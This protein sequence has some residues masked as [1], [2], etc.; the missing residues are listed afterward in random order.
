M[1][2]TFA[3]W[4]CRRSPAAKSL[5]QPSSRRKLLSSNDEKVKFGESVPGGIW[6]CIPPAA[7]DQR[8]AMMVIG[9]VKACISDFSLVCL[10]HGTSNRNQIDLSLVYLDCIRIQSNAR[11]CYDL[12]Y[13]ARLPRTR[14]SSDSTA[15][16]TQDDRVYFPALFAGIR[17]FLPA[18]A[19]A[20]SWPGGCFHRQ[21][22]T[23]SPAS[24]FTGCSHVQRANLR[25]QGVSVH[26][27]TFSSLAGR[28][29]KS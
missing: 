22:F 23:P 12:K 7:F 26:R 21:S 2:M 13:V 19:S 3:M 4:L 5:R 10:S 9:G 25:V 8:K 15:K 14:S 18:I 11:F 24:S 28:A 1:V 27:R 17:V 16:G 29:E 20:L 6:A